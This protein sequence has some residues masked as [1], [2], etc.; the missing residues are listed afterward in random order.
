VS[1]ESA[2]LLQTE[3]VGL[4]LAAESKQKATMFGSCNWLLAGMDE[5]PTFSTGNNP[6]KPNWEGHHPAVHYCWPQQGTL[7]NKQQF[8]QLAIRPFFGQ[9]GK[10]TIQ[11]Y[12]RRPPGPQSYCTTQQ[13]KKRHVDGMSYMLICVGCVILGTL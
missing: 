6:T 3:A 4:L 13:V 9:I 7:S 12:S 2:T 8:C 10:G 1:P 11:L 5:A